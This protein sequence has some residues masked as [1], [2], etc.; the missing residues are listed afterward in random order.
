MDGE[1][2]LVLHH[3]DVW[4]IVGY[5]FGEYVGP[6]GDF[7]G[8]GVDDIV[9]TSMGS[10]NYNWALGN[11]YVYAGDSTL[12]VDA[13]DIGYDRHLPSRFGSLQQNFPNP[14]NI[15]TTIEYTLTG[16]S[17]REVELTIHNI[18]GQ[19]IRTLK[20]CMER[21]GRHVVYWD[22]TD[23]VGEPVASGVYFY[24]LESSEQRLSKRLLLL[25]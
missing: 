14:F 16:M 21:G 18:L 4:P 22:G 11:V 9:V 13:E 2:D 20:R 23:D 5:H 3:S 8:D 12:P 25:K 6:A 24:V 15:G 19:K 10:I 17:Q 1:A 7:N